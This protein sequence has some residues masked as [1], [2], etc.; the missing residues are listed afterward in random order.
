MKELT[1]KDVREQY[2][3]RHLSPWISIVV[4][5][6]FEIIIPAACIL[7]VIFSAGKISVI[8][9]F[10]MLICTIEVVLILTFFFFRG[11]TYSIIKEFFSIKNGHY[12]IVR[13]KCIKE[14]ISE[15]SGEYSYMHFW[16]FEAADKTVKL[17]M[18]INEWHTGYLVVIDGEVLAV[19]DAEKYSVNDYCTTICEERD[20]KRQKRKQAVDSVLGIVLLE[21]LLVSALAMDILGILNKAWTIA[22]A[23]GL[24]LI[25]YIV[26]ALISGTHPKTSGILSLIYLFANGVIFCVLSY[27]YNYSTAAYIVGVVYIALS[28]LIASLWYR[29]WR[30]SSEI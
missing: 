15:T 18:G 26:G 8:D 9:L 1:N 6:L 14:E 2:K 10:A 16:T 29:N 12:R 21:S 22:L 5:A 4:V 3:K 24:F 19:F 7:C 13:A 27:L 30:K 28:L 11:A 17:T 25:F 20:I 23:G